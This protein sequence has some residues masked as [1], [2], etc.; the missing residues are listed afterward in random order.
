MCYYMSRAVSELLLPALGTGATGVF[1]GIGP[2]FCTL[3]FIDIN[4]F[5]HLSQSSDR[6]RDSKAPWHSGSRTSI[7]HLS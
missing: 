6:P 2:E 7:I 4:C 1:R 3:H 5:Q